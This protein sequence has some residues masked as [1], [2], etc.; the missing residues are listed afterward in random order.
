[1]FQVRVQI[2]CIKSSE[3]SRL[4]CKLS[5]KDSILDDVA[6]LGIDP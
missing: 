6:E 5:T 2:G 1:M 3:F 4:K